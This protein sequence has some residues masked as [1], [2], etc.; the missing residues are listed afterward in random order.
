M[1][2]RAPSERHRRELTASVIR[3]VVQQQ[4]NTS[5]IR[6]IANPHR[7]LRTYTSSQQGVEGEELVRSERKR[8]RQPQTST[9]SEPTTERSRKTCLRYLK[10]VASRRAALRAP[11]HGSLA[12]RLLFPAA[13][14]RCARAH[15][16]PPPSSTPQAPPRSGTKHITWLVE[17][18]RVLEEHQRAPLILGPLIV[19]IQRHRVGLL[20]A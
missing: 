9:K 17:A 11:S 15:P 1:P 3:I 5:L 8:E 16:G 14:A 10:M 20:P 4:C 12:T 6:S 13:A 7:S 2:R 19:S 18:L